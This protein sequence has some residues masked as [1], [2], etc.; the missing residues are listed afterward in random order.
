MADL[1]HAGLAGIAPLNAVTFIENHDTDRNEPVATNKLLGYAYILTSEGYPCVYYRDYSTDKNCFGLKSSIDN[2]IWIHEKLAEGPTQ[3]RWKDF[4]LFAYERLGGPGLLVA[5]NND[6]ASPRTVEVATAFGANVALHD[7]TGN[8][9]NIVTSGRGAARIT[10]PRNAEGRGYVC[11]S[12]TGIDGGFAVTSRTTTQ[13]FEGAAD[14]DLPPADSGKAVQAGRSG[15]HRSARSSACPGWRLIARSRSRSPVP[16]AP[17]SGA[18]HSK[19]PQR[20]MGPW[21]QGAANWGST[22]YG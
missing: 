14:L 16:T 17:C 10:V 7:Y 5:L 1:A 21:R 9:P 3:E 15:I 19:G 4:D 20:G 6:P 11:Y 12:R 8:G 18:R 22:R 13:E 2:L